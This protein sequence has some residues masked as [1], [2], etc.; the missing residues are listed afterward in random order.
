MTIFGYSLHRNLINT[1]PPHVNSTVRTKYSSLAM[2]FGKTFCRCY[3]FVL[4]I[5]A[6]NIYVDNE[7]YLTMK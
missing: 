6:V 1:F 7:K 2:K 5:C 3:K 4:L